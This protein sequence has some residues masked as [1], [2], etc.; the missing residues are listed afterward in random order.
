MKSLKILVADDEEWDRRFAKQ[1]IRSYLQGRKEKKQE[2]LE[3]EVKEAETPEQANQIIDK[4]QPDLILLDIL[5]KED[6]HSSSW[7]NEVLKPYRKTGGRAKIICWSK[8]PSY[9]W[10]VKKAGANEFLNKEVYYNLKDALIVQLETF[11]DYAL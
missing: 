10:I 6:T 4:L 9:E 1:Y 2:D 11:G 3:V 5:L 7:I 8:D